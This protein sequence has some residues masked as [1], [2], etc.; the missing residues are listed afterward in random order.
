MKHFTRSVVAAAVAIVPIIASGTTAAHAADDACYVATIDL[1]LTSAST[2]HLWTLD[3]TVDPTGAGSTFLQANAALDCEYLQ[4]GCTG[5]TGGDGAVD[6][7]TNI[8]SFSVSGGYGFD[9]IA[10]GSLFRCRIAT[11]GTLPLAASFAV[12]VTSA[13]GVESSPFDPVQPATASVDV[14]SISCG[15]ACNEWPREGCRTTGVSSLLIDPFRSQKLVWK[16]KKGEALDLGAISDPATGHYTVCIYPFR[17]ETGGYPLFIE[18]ER[19]PVSAGWSPI[20][21]HGYRYR[22]DA[23][24]S[25]HVRRLDVK[26]GNDG[27]TSVRLLAGD[28]REDFVPATGVRV[29]LLDPLSDVCWE[30]NYSGYPEDDNVFKGTT[31]D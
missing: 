25:G 7:D 19:L 5:C 31:G 14:V 4:D 2:D 9:E 13:S 29:Q 8:A 24:S 22:A 18:E 17:S 30:S 6:P 11:D 3:F 1:Q 15:A 26:T 10:V 16:W 20:G 28:P 12:E 21:T 27:R 23:Q